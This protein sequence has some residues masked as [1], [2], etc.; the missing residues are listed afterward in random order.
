VL[1]PGTT[2]EVLKMKSIVLLPFDKVAESAGIPLTVKSLAWTVAGSTGSLTL[3]MKSVGWVKTVRPHDGLVTVQGVEV[4]VG[5]AV[6]LGVG[7]GVGVD[8]ALQK[9]SIDLNGVTPSLA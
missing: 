1:T 6:A 8:P 5:V 3:V 9:I 7:V 2:G 4:G